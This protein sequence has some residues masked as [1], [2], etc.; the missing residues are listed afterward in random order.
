MEA[1]DERDDGGLAGAGGAYKGGNGAGSG[2]EAD[3]MED[4]LLGLIGEGD[5]LEGDVAAD[6]RKVVGAAGLG[7]LFA[8]GEYLGGA[9]EAGDGFGELGAY[10]D[11]LDDGSDHE[12][13]KHDVGDVAAG[14]EASGDDLVGAEIH[15][16]GTDDAEDGGGGQGHEGLG[17][18]GR[19]DVLEEAVGAGGEDVG[20]ALLGV[21]ALD[22]ADA[23][24][25]FGEAAGDLGVDLGAL[26][27]D[28]ADG[29]EGAL[30][31]GSENEKDDEG[32]ERH[33][34]AE[35]DEIGE[36]EDGGKDAAEE[37]DDACADEVTDAFDVGHDARYEG[38]G[39]VLVIEGY[40]QAADVGLDLHAEFGD[41]A[42]TR[43]G[44]ELG[45]RERGY[46]L[47][48]GRGD[49]Y[50]HDGR[51]Q[52]KLMLSHHVIDEVFCGSWQNQTTCTIY[53]HQQEASAEE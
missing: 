42:L 15:D 49:D 10:A 3:A 50:A 17:G 43:F 41:E 52:M 48:D 22:D 21:V 23:A 1:A 14:G 5:V 44:E 28:G 11:K 13:E 36:G 34:D 37:V 25:G 38:S 32:D 6:G 29:F 46:A 27:E 12:R 35:L 20:L 53:Y 2:L 24:E 40:G 8:L 4:G 51:E 39:A 31:D 26:A 19:D 45:E 16:E 33:L 9:V 18:E 47:E 30:E 7:V